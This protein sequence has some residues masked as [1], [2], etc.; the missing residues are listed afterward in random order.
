[1]GNGTTKFEK[2]LSIEADALLESFFNA[3]RWKTARAIQ[4]D[5]TCRSTLRKCLR[6][7]E[8]G[9]ERR[10]HQQTAVSVLKILKKVCMDFH[11]RRVRH[12]NRLTLMCWEYDDSK[13]RYRTGGDKSRWEIAVCKGVG[14]VRKFCSTRFVYERKQ[15][16]ITY[17]GRALQD[18][19]KFRDVCVT[20]GSFINMIFLRKNDELAEI[21]LD[22]TEMEHGTPQECLE[23]SKN[24][25]RLLFSLLQN[26]NSG[27]DVRLHVWHLLCTLPKRTAYARMLVS[28]VQAGCVPGVPELPSDIALCV[29][30]FV[31][32]A[33]QEIYI[34]EL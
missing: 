22:V 11:M 29:A 10:K 27:S 30:S 8:C 1:M 26:K 12:P 15:I 6:N 19:E 24:W 33:I 21:A 34:D 14:H 23:K 17:Q 20:S 9:T 2:E 28:L 18:H 31:P 5:R 4:F 16:Q 25:L 13:R 3:H 32:S 7:F